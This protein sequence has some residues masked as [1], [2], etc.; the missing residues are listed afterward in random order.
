MQGV[1]STQSSIRYFRPHFNVLCRR[2]AGDF[3]LL[4]NDATSV[5]NLVS[6]F[7]ARDVSASLRADGS[8]END[9]SAFDNDS[10]F[11]GQAGIR[12][13]SDTSIVSFNSDVY[14]V[15]TRQISTEH[16]MKTF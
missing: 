11:P 13:H 12:S 2:K 1:S 9:L 6:R 3:V 8:K 15:Q 10:N 5:C 4:E 16:L 7:R 14:S